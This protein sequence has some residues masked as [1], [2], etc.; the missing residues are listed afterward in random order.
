MDSQERHEL[1]QNDLYEFL[2]HFKQWWEKNGTGTL[3]IICCLLGGVVGYRWYS[4]REA[5]FLNDAWSELAMAQEPEQMVRV[6]E[7]Y[8]DTPVAAKALLRAADRLQEQAL[9][10]IPDETGNAPPRILNPEQTQQYRER[11]VKLY[12]NVLEQGHSG[13]QPSL[14]AL[15]ARLG[16]AAAYESLGQFDQAEQQY[17]ALQEEA[18]V[19]GILASKAAVGLEQLDELREPVI[20]PDAPPLPPAPILPETTGTVD[21]IMPEVTPMPLP[22]FQ[23]P[24][25]LPQPDDEATEPSA[26]QTDDMP[27][28]NPLAPETP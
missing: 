12:Q 27:L 13:D 6:A 10:G 25:E 19:H 21:P 15:N 9:F 28:N 7:D 14:I 1:K 24:L 26:D 8:P 5:R 4:G 20:F 2:T 17:R 16:L 11:A 18:G 22:G 3:L 23:N